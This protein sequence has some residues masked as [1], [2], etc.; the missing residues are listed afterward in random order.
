MY[1]E[2]TNYCCFCF[3]WQCRYC[4]QSY[5]DFHRC[6]KVRGAEYEACKYF[7]MCYQSMC[8]SAWVEKWDEQVSEGRFAGNI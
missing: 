7:K 3:V 4:Y 2:I 1:N 8:P 6:S 5:L